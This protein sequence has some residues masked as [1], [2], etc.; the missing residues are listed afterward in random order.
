MLCYSSLIFI[1]KCYK[2]SSIY[3][4]TAVVNEQNRKQKNLTVKLTKDSKFICEAVVTSWKSIILDSSIIQ[5]SKS[6]PALSE[7]KSGSKV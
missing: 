4:F 7:I 6:I 2:V 1:I 3:Q 5:E